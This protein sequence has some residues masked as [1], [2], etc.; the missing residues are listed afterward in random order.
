MREL[1]E[2]PEAPRQ[3]LGY[4]VEGRVQPLQSETN[5]N[6]HCL[7]GPTEFTPYSFSTKAVVNE[8]NN[9]DFM[10]K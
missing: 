3:W 10:L 2:V 4:D 5:H 8:I 9:Y 6:H 7:I 1:G